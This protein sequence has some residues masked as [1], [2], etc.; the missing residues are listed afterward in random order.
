MTS[1][2]DEVNPGFTVYDSHG[3][4]IG[5]VTQAT[6][7]FVLVRGGGIL[8]HDTYI[9]PSA[10][11]NVEERSVYLNCTQGDLEAQGWHAAPGEGAGP[12]TAGAA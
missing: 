11:E 9:P 5:S 4:E 3:K 2:I 1:Q 8:R 7:R 10:I 6:S 12:G